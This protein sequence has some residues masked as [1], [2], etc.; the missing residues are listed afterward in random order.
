M[1]RF[2]LTCLI[3]IH[4]LAISHAQYIEVKN[5]SKHP[6]KELISI[7]F[8]KFKEHF[9]VD[10]VFSI[11]DE[12]NQHVPFQLERLGADIPV[13]VL[14]QV[15]LPA[16]TTIKYKLDKQAGTGIEP[17][18]FARYVPERFDDFAWENDVVAFR[19]YGK[20][21][22]GRKDD[23]QGMDYWAKRTDKLIINKWY[24][25]ENYHQDNGEGMDYYTV[26]QTLGAGDVAL[27]SHKG[28]KFTKHYRRYQILD[29]GPL[30]TTFKLEYDPEELDGQEVK[31]NKIISLDAGSNFNK[32]VLQV[33]NSKA[34]NTAIAIGVAKRKENQPKIAVGQKNETLAYWEPEIA[35][36]GQTGIAVIIPKQKVSIDSNRPEQFLLSSKASNH[37]DF[38]YYN[39]AV[40]N[41]GGKVCSA[42]EW[43][44]AVEQELERINKPIKWVLK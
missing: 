37:K 22:E 32:I 14:I 15:E 26:G 25:V 36:N 11:L 19:L 10:T 5:P 43:N 28:L 24:K 35:N 40:W 23:G 7:P 30:R 2:L 34:S 3:I 44:K 20:A 13:N 6:R 38:V 42:E 31:L 27:L 12:S 8:Q 39:G 21:L 17:K 9:K 1:K 18:T 41:R 16:L 33:Q 29:N 4:C